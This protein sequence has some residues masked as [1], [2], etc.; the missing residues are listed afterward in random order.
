VFS[1]GCTDRGSVAR[2][3]RA[4]RRW[5]SACGA[6]PT[7]RRG[8]H[9]SPDKKMADRNADRRGAAAAARREVRPKAEPHRCTAQGFNGTNPSSGG[10]TSGWW[11]RASKARSRLYTEINSTI[12]LQ[13]YTRYWNDSVTLSNARAIC[14]YTPSV[15][16]PATTVG[17]I[18]TSGTSTLACRYD[19]FT[20]S[21]YR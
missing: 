2:L 19:H 21:K 20:T 11:I 14:W 8:H 4:V 15:I 9:A 18:A 3:G 16:T 1:G 6:H 12:V 7:L 5:G 17:P 13:L 10:A